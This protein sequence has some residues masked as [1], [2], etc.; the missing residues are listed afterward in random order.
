MPACSGNEHWF[1][2][3]FGF[4]EKKAGGWSQVQANFEFNPEDML[5]VSR[6]NRIYQ[7]RTAEVTVFNLHL[8]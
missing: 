3:E 2:Q 1:E 7:P 6:Y 8:I 4:N 5:L